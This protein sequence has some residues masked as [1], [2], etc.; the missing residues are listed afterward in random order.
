MGSEGMYVHVI[1]NRSLEGFSSGLEYFS[2]LQTNG[3][4]F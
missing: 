3:H 1:Y 4:S 2:S